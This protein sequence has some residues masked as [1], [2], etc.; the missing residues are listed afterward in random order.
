MI[1]RLHGALSISSLALSPILFQAS[2]ARVFPSCFRSSSSFSLV[3]PSS[4]LSLALRCTQRV[5]P[6]SIAGILL[7]H[8][9]PL[10]FQFLQPGPTRSV[11]PVSI[12]RSFS[13]L[14]PRYLTRVTVSNS[15]PIICMDTT[16]YAA[17]ILPDNCY[18]SFH[19]R[20]AKWN[21]AS[22]SPMQKR[23]ANWLSHI[24]SVV[25]IELSKMHFTCWYKSRVGI[26]RR[27]VYLKKKTQL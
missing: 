3:Y 12:P 19:H 25:F 20:F 26:R 4:T 8:N 9:T 16:H 2:L 27:H 14:L 1:F 17:T 6:F 23:A 18:D 24:Q 21:E 13:T 5:C 7:S 22:F 11:I 15:S 10:H